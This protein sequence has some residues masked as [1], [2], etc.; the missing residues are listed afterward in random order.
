ALVEHKPGGG[1]KR[2]TVTQ[3][4]PEVV[5]LDGATLHHEPELAEAALD[6]A[7]LNHIMI[8]LEIDLAPAQELPVAPSHRCR[9]AGPQ[10]AGQDQEN[11]P[12]CS[13]H[14]S[15]PS[16]VGSARVTLYYAQSERGWDLPPSLVVRFPQ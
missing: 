16:S 10:P 2:L 4:D 6:P 13:P 1:A 12:P 5:H 3:D 8:E 11:P 9:R 7:H 15:S 14:Q